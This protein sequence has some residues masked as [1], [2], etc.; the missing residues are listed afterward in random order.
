MV[1]RV[2][3]A[4]KAAREKLEAERAERRAARLARNSE[5]PTKVKRIPAQPIGTLREEFVRMRA[6]FWSKP[7]ERLP[8]KLERARIRRYCKRLIVF[9]LSTDDI[10]ADHLLTYYK[11][12][13]ALY[14]AKLQRAEGI[15]EYRQW[16][17]EHK[18]ETETKR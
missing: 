12:M 2:H 18:H 15:R 5:K 9:D 6:E 3:P 1:Y 17:K 13:A 8:D 16:E 10:G 7:Y 14:R 4:R 11:R